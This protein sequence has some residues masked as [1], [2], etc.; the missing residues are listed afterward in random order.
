MGGLIQ[1]PPFWHCNILMSVIHGT[2]LWEPGLTDVL[3]EVSCSNTAAAMWHLSLLYATAADC[4][5]ILTCSRRRSRCKEYLGDG[6]RDLASGA[7]CISFSSPCCF[8]HLRHLC[9]HSSAVLLLSS[10]DLWTHEEMSKKKQTVQTLISLV[11]HSL[12]HVV[13]RTA[14]QL[15]MHVM[16]TNNLGQIMATTSKDSYQKVHCYRQIL[17]NA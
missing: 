9:N 11:H 3:F 16:H 14:Q 12:A 1:K 13:M 17:L 5:G 8:H 7:A 6:R 10:S 2:Q 4:L 15:Q